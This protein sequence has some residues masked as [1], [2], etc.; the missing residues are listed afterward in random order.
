MSTPRPVVVVGLDGR[1]QPMYRYQ[2]ELH[3]ADH[4]RSIVAAEDRFPVSPMA[5]SFLES[6]RT[7]TL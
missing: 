6:A 7:G 5:T 3:L 4:L 2:D 1:S